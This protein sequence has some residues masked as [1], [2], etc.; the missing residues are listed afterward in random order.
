MPDGYVNKRP[1]VEWWLGQVNGGLAFRKKFAREDSWDKWR[2]YYRGHWDQGTMPVNLFFTLLRT[3]VPRVYFRNPSVSISPA[4]PGPEHMGFARVLQRVDNKMIQQMR[5]KREIKRMVQDT[6]LFGTSAGKLGYGALFTP[7]PDTESSVTIQPITKDGERFEYRDNVFANMPWFSRMPTKS[8]VVPAHTASYEDARWVG[9]IIRRPLDDIKRDTR[10]ENTGDLTGGSVEEATGRPA[11]KWGKLETPIEMVDLVEIRDKKFRKVMVI[12]FH[13]GQLGKPIFYGDDEFLING[14]VPIFPLVF[15]ED[16]EVFWGIPDSA[17][18]EPQQLEINEIRTQRMKH[19]RMAIVKLMYETGTITEAE[20]AKMLSEDV[21]AGVE[22]SDIGGVKPTQVSDVPTSLL[23]EQEGVM[24]DVREL[25]G[26]SRNQMGN[27]GTTGKGGNRTTATEANIVQLASE[28]RVDERRDLI[29][30]MLQDIIEACHVI[31]FN[32][33]DQEQVIDVVGPGGVPFWVKFTGKMLRESQYTVKID[34]DTSLP[35]TKELRAQ[36]AVQVYELLKS[37][38]LIDPMKL[39]SYLL[40]ELH[41]VQFDDM[42][43]M[44][45]PSPEAQGGTVT[46][47]QFGGVLQDQITAAA[48]NPESLRTPASVIERPNGAGNA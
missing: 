42:I 38:P 22:V 5:I 20:L 11:L 17:I 31:I 18:L 28:I 35:E 29:A 25:I 40:S 23:L 41:G 37:S 7:T 16:D 30:D 21:M 45:P 33:W 48:K 3:I 12:P 46:P 24:Q 34:P 4:K 36:R 1:D 27:F 8:L 9:H 32:Q 13:T 2:S 10:F 19:R 14:A 6:F 47:G 39:T 15:N 44:L 43:R 26:F